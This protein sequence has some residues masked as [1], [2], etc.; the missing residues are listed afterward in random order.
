VKEAI[1]AGVNFIDTA[2]TYAGGDSETTIGSALSSVPDRAVV[3][4][5]GGWNSGRPDALRSE[6]EQSLRRLRTERIGLYYLHRVDPKTP[7]EESVGAIKDARDA[8]NI[9]H[10]G[11]SNV[12]IEEIERAR[13]VVPIAAVQNHYNLFERAHDGVVDHCE[14]EGIAF[15]PYFPLRAVGGATL[16]EIAERRGATTAQVA[17]AWL[18]QRSPMTVPIPGTLSLSHLKE[19][20]GALEMELT[21]AEFRALAEREGP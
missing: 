9:E 6:I 19:N 15:V 4:T 11:V 10:V 1:G 20:L 7:I 5:K 13:Q 12:G 17:L 21:E 2:H 14:R 8:G 18:L 16:E 3:A